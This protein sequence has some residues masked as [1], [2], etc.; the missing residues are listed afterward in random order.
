MN[1][2]SNKIRDLIR[3]FVELD[4]NY[5]NKLLINLIMLQYEQNA[6]TSVKEQL[7]DT[8]HS[9]SKSYDTILDNTI[10]HKKNKLLQDAMII[11]EKVNTFDNEQVAQFVCLM[12]HIKPGVFTKKEEIT[13][14]IDSK[15]IPLNE[16]LYSLFPEVSYEKI[17]NDL[18]LYELTKD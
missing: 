8:I 4:E 10:M 13:I 1:I 11:C 2:D 6:A 17:R 3:G 18:K 15:Q 16:Y 5:Q 14:Q 7:S 9:H 12:E